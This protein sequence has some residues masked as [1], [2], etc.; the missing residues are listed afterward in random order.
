VR[1]LA[2]LVFA[3][4]VA[5]GLFAGCGSGVPIPLPVAPTPTPRA[6][7]VGASPPAEV[8]QASG[9]AGLC[10]HFALDGVAR[11]TGHYN[12][13]DGGHYHSWTGSAGESFWVQC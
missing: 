8:V 9:G 5:C 12:A 7:E 2:S 1:R 4:V 13:S 11:F 10:S 3:A 6:A